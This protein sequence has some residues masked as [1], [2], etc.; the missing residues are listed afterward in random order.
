MYQHLRQ[1][2]HHF[3]GRQLHCSKQKLDIV[4]RD[5]LVCEPGLGTKVNHYTVPRER[6][7]I[8]EGRQRS[9]KDRNK[10]AQDPERI[11]ILRFRR[12]VP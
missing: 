9:W 10:N 5:D 8:Y 12:N 7:H 11:Y 4:Y 3:L 1:R 2:L 6:S